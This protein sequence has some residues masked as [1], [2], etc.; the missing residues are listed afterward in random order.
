[1]EKKFISEWGMCT[2]FFK[3]HD[4]S[5]NWNVMPLHTKQQPKLKQHNNDNKQN[6]IITIMTNNKQSKTST[7]I[8]NIYLQH[9]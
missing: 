4:G 6:K 7:T 5:I 3:L 2:T 1:M 9:E 8:Y